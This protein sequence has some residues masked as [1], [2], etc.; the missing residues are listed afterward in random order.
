VTGRV[1]DERYVASLRLARSYHLDDL[2]L[3]TFT[4]RA[5]CLER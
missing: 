2:R 5:S 4:L 1:A 3:L